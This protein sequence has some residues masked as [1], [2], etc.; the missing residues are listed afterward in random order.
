MIGHIC[1][2]VARSARVASLHATGYIHRAPVPRICIVQSSRR[3]SSK[4]VKSTQTGVVR[5]QQ[6]VVPASQDGK[7]RE[8][9]KHHCRRGLRLFRGP[10][11]TQ[12]LFEIPDLTRL[13]RVQGSNRCQRAQS[14]SG[15]GNERAT[16]STCGKPCSTRSEPQAQRGSEERHARR[17]GGLCSSHGIERLR[18]RRAG[19]EEEAAEPHFLPTISR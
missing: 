6:R 11:G 14:Q 17:Q 10:P 13:N 8:S 19:R 12:Y 7:A 4:M 18:G 15:A 3:A 2:S 5:W 16:S 1:Q 9:K